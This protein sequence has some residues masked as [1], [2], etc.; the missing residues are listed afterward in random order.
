MTKTQI[1]GIRGQE[2][3]GQGQS[4]PWYFFTRKLFLTYR[5]NRG[6]EKMSNGGEKNKNCEREGETKMEG[7]E[8]WNCAEDF[9]SLFF[10][11]HFSKPLKSVWGVPKWK[12]STR[13]KAFFIRGKNLE[14]WFCPFWKIMF[15]RHWSIQN[16]I[17]LLRLQSL[18]NPSG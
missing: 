12:I 11:C 7:E 6:K 1:N 4:A 18:R 15:L 16:T 10:A 2:A 13:K 17:I 3:G 9:F 14:K 8:V 5:E